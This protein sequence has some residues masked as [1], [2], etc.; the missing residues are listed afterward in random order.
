MTLFG[1]VQLPFQ[2]KGRGGVEGALSCE[3]QGSARSRLQGPGLTDET[4]NAA[5]SKHTC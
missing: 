5:T 2:Q 3:T 1:S 4:Q